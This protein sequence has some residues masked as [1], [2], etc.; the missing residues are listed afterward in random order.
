MNPIT[1]RLVSLP[2]LRMQVLEAGPADG[3]LVLLL[4]GFPELSE[5]WR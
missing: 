3:P 2:G 5:S 1:P 4:H